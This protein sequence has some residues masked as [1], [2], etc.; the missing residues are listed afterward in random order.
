MTCIHSDTN[1]LAQES[2]KS[3]AGTAEGLETEKEEE[4]KDP[5]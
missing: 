2:W 1:R 3:R 5:K 4:K